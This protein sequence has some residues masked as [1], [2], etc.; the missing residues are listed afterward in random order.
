MSLTAISHVHAAA[1]KTSD[2]A[3]IKTVIESMATLADRNEYEALERIFADE[4]E[5]DYRT[6]AGGEV[7]VKSNQALM[8]A[9]AGLLPGFDRTRHRITDIEVEIDGS[10]ATGRSQVTAAHWLDDLYWEVSGNYQYGFR[11]VD[12]QWVITKL[13]FVFISEKGTRDVF[14]LAVEN[15]A[16]NP[17]FYIARQK[18]RQTVIDFLDA[19]RSKDRERF[20]DLWADDAVQDLPL[21]ADRSLQRKVGRD[22]ILKTY[23]SHFEGKIPAKITPTTVLY[24]MQTAEVIL[25]EFGGE[26]DIWATGE[27]RKSKYACLFHVE[28]GKISLLRAYD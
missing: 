21:S 17:D 13:T 5:V 3:A 12:R 6:L 14:P 2:T 4:V 28:N 23:S 10:E 20:A 16:K 19:L 9:W 22:N 1:D 11:K 8:T 7:E 15:A 25:V 26:L 27:E 18:T 24:P